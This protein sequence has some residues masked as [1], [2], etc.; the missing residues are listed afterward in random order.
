M[1]QKE[2]V[3][4]SVMVTV[5]LQSVTVL[6]SAVQTGVGLLLSVSRVTTAGRSTVPV[7]VKVPVRVMLAGVT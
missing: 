4:F 5:Q 3:A 6:K 7:T 2:E 1:T